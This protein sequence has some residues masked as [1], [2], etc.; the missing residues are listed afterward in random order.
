MSE[1]NEVLYDMLDNSQKMNWYTCEAKVDSETF[2]CY[3]EE[4]SEDG[5][6]K[7]SLPAYAIQDSE[8]GVDV[9]LTI[10]N[11]ENKCIRDQ[12]VRWFGVERQNF[13]VHNPTSIDFV[14]KYLAHG[15]FEKTLVS[16]RLG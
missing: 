7:I 10:C 13:Q 1:Y 11:Q 5:G 16:N 9:D 6:H 3:V 8:N 4:D 2:P 12:R 14:H 15:R